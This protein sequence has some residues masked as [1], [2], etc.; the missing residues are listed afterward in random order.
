[1]STKKKNVRADLEVKLTSLGG[2][3]VFAGGRGTG[4][5]TTGLLDAQ[6]AALDDLALE[7]FL[8]S[9]GLLGS[10]HVDETK[11]TRLL[12]MRVQ[13]NGAVV[14]IA[15]LLEQARDVGL[16]QARVNAGDEQVGARVLG[17]FLILSLDF[18][19]LVAKWR[20]K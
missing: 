17:T 12:G 10:G 7:A 14:D 16:G 5:A 15:V 1:M 6:G 19:V 3:K 11:A 13:H 4:T 2:S 8:G 18:K 9:I 20:S